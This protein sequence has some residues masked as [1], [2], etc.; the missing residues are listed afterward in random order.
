MAKNN[1]F[2]SDQ[3]DSTSVKLNFYSRYIENYLIIILMQFGT[4]FV[5]DFFCGKGVNGDKK[6][7]PLLLLELASK[8]LNN[9][10]LKIKHKNAKITVLF[11]DENIENINDLKEELKNKKSNDQIRVFIENKT[12]QELMMG[13][14]IKILKN[15]K[16]PKFIFL[17]PFSYSAIS[18]EELKILMKIPKTEILLFC[19]TSHACRFSGGDTTPPK[20]INFFE[21]YTIDG[22]VKYKDIYAMVD[23][24]HERLVKE[25]DTDFVKPIV[26]NAGSNKH[27]LFYITRHIKGMMIMN[28]IFLKES[29]DARSISVKELKKKKTQSS[30]FKKTEV[31]TDDFREHLMEYQE[32]LI[33]C[34]REKGEMTN[35][36]I[37]N[38]SVVNGWLPKYATAILRCIKDDVEVEY[39][40]EGKRIGFY[41]SEENWNKE[42]CIVRYKVV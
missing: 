15:S 27:T 11:N 25:L 29:F 30:L 5:G 24:I 6:G 21:D 37:I 31:E 1:N 32:D 36:E 16:I 18:I 7:S 2:F 8:T 41:V 19:P 33:E 39:S 12:F 3:K 20:L 42:F 28:K 14:K 34:L 35:V 13:N 17:D 10:T 26:I 4:C 23:S 22:N 40:K 9:S 38:H